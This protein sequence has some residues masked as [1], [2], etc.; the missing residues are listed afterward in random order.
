[1]IA[2]MLAR[3]Y[4]Y[5]RLRVHAVQWAL[6][7]RLE[8]DNSCPSLALIETWRYVLWFRRTRYAADQI[9]A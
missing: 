3:I 1:M 6:L 4:M 5:V 7:L 9:S 2:R 8:V